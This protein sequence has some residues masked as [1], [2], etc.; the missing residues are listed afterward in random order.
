MSTRAAVL[1]V[2]LCG[3]V[4]VVGGQGVCSYDSRMGATF[5]L[6]DLVRYGDMP[7]YSVTDGDIP[8]TPEVEQNFTYVFNICNQ[9]HHNVYTD[10]GRDESNQDSLW[11]TSQAGVC[12]LQV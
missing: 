10:T 6:Q 1:L 5:D 4:G 8:C 3:V 7:A 11:Y 9:V 2:A 12:I